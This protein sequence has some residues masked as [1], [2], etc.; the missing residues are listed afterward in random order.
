M[1]AWAIKAAGELAGPSLLRWLSE[2]DADRPWFAVLNY[3][4]AHR[5]LVPARTYRERVMTPEQVAHSY[6]VDRSWL[7]IW[8]YTVGLREYS[9][10]D[11]AAMAGTYD[12][13]I[14]ELDDLFADLLAQLEAAGE[15]EDTAIILTADHGELLGEH[16]MLDHQ[17]SL[18][19][20]L[21][22]VPLV[23][24]YPPLV[25]SGREARPV[26]TLDLYP[27][28]LELAGLD[29]SAKRH[30][31]ARSLLTPADSR[32]RVAEYSAAN[33]DPLLGV[34]RQYPGWRADPWN[35]V[36]RLL[37]DGRYQFIWASDGRH[38]LYDLERDPRE[39]HNLM[40]TE[41]AIG[42]RMQAELDSIVAVLAEKR[43]AQP[44]RELSPE[45]RELLQGL[46]Y[47]TSDEGEHESDA[48]NSADATSSD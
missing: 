15:L 22:A 12:A 26:M 30:S 39:L 34:E 8:S 20:P 21:T 7:P 14:A 16:H 2:G 18:H 25:E 23:V 41:P 11:L 27:T 47:L 32:A 48:A 46:G 37:D 44:A 1:G 29:A 17:Y 40:E 3:M 42:A 38:E 4:E 19:R 5:P 43:P 35:R 45:T 10:R 24:H 28:L 9:D 13:A 36:L 33:I 6:T 31:P